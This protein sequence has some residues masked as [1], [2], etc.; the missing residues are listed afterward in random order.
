V[1]VG[2]DRCSCNAVVVPPQVVVGEGV[3]KPSCCFGVPN[4]IGTNTGAWDDG[5]RGLLTE[6]HNNSLHGGRGCLFCHNLSASSAGEVW[7]VVVVIGRT[8]MG[9]LDEPAAESVDKHAK[10][11]ACRRK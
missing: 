8:M 2:S 9:W 5:D 4:N 6:N 10:G 1:S 3:A 11:G 7:V